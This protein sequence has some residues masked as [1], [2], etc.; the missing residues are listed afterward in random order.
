V[1][2]DEL[3]QAVTAYMSRAAAKLRRQQSVAGVINVFIQ[4][5]P[6]KNTPQVQRGLTLP[7]PGMSD[8]TRVLVR[9]ALAGLRQIYVPGYAYKKTGVMLSEIT[10]AATRQRTL[11]DDVPGMERSRALCAHS[12]ISIARWGVGR[13]GC[14]GR[15]FR[16]RGPCAARRCRR[17]IRRG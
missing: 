4:T 9:T 10:A 3:A 12:M 6:F 8:D 7:E 1:G 14:W 15:G 13:Y 5:N 11:F 17:T 16:R 2:L